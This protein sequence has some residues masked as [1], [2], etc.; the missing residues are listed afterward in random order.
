MGPRSRGP[1]PGAA[2]NV[3]PGPDRIVL[4]GLEVFAHH[5][6]L[7]DEK[8]TG[9]VFRVDLT[10]HTD[11]TDAAASDD[12]GEA[13]DY[14][15]IADRVHDLVASTRFDLIETVAETVARTVLEFDR[16]D[17]VDVII[18]KPDAPIGHAFSDVAVSISRRSA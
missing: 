16:V 6:V 18:H 12:L 1:L 17:A 2:G 5:G 14:G 3:T 13:V 8:E 15:V 4:T 10:V 7:S 11:I 9:Q